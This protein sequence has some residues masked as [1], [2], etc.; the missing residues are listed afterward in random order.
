MDRTRHPR[1]VA[2][3]LACERLTMTTDNS[4]LLGWVLAGVGG[5]MTVLA[6]AVARLFQMRESEN[7]KAIAE[8]KQE[9]AVTKEAAAKCERDRE[10]L[11]AA[12][13]V[14]KVEIAHLKEKISSI[15]QEGTKFSHTLQARND[16]QSRTA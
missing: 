9:V 15:D 8:L 5:I 6:G 2:E 7:S 3:R 10:K 4:S 11:F 13:E 12:C 16:S 14:N 1:R